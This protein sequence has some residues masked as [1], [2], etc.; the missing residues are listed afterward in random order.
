[1]TPKYKSMKEIPQYDIQEMD[2]QIKHRKNLK[3]QMVGNMYPRMLTDEIETLK[4][5]M[6][7]A[8]KTRQAYI[9]I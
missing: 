1:M 9:E 7:L 6:K 3:S 4:S 5:M 2:I 8:K